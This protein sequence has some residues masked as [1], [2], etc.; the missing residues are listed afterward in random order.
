MKRWVIVGFGL[1]VLGSPLQGQGLREK[2]QDLFVFGEGRSPLI[3]GGTA[4][5]P[6]ENVRV[7]GDH[8]TPAAVGLNGDLISFLE[9]AIAT[10]VGNLPVSATSSG[11]EYERGALDILIPV[12]GSAGPIFAESARTLGRGRVFVGGNVSR[13]D[14]K[15]IRGINLDAIGLNFT[16]DD[17][18]PEGTLGDPR[19]ENEVI[20]VDLSL[21]VEV[22]AVS[23][24][25]T[26]GLAEK[27]DIGFALPIVSTTLGGSS[28]A[29]VV[30][31]G[32]GSDPANP[33]AVHFFGGTAD[34]P[35]LSASSS[36]RGSASGIGDVAARIKIAVSESGQAK[37]AILGDVRFPTGSESD[38]LGTGE[39][40][41]RG[42]GVLSARFGDFSPHV[43]AGYSYR[44]GTFQTDAVLMTAGFTHALAPWATLA[45]DIVSELQ[46]G[47]N[48][49]QLPEPVQITEPFRRTI[50][51]T[52]I[53]TRRDDIVNGSL[54]LKF[55]TRS[56][57]TI[58]VN[59]LWP[60]NRG[61]LRPNVIWTAGLQYGF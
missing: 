29:Q 41:I 13:I 25:V 40:S 38:L 11:V 6:E 59:S 52:N 20:H 39:F 3:L 7:H 24:V 16:H 35:E 14:F 30:P 21:D 44:G 12:P 36:V 15:S 58:L 27:V 46:V 34:N 22:T 45:I 53:P 33:E 55:E 49:I 23:F 18:P 9:T 5:T 26:Y 50:Q 51:P 61:G 57:V 47:D 54:G 32:S 4:D 1:A 37:L 48:A 19:L 43:N 42:L 56:N 17:T 28:T 31:F 2:L 8:F 60:M 10:N